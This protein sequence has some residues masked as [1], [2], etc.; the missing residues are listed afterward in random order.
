M[1]GDVLARGNSPEGLDV[2]VRPL[3]DGARA[4][5]SR[6]PH[7]ELEE[8]AQMRA[9]GAFRNDELRV[10]AKGETADRVEHVELAAAHSRRDVE[11]DLAEDDH[12][13]ARHVLARVVA[14]TFDDRDGAGV[15]HRETLAY[16]SRAEEL[17]AGRAVENG[18]AEQHGVAGIVASRQD[19]DSPAPHPLADAVVRLADE[20]ELDAGAEAGGEALPGRGF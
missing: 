15:A 14:G 7:V 16:A 10:E 20:L 3:E 19:R 6:V 1:C 4:W 13:A 8:L 12:S 9:C 2:R 18:V 17:A 5:R 11:P